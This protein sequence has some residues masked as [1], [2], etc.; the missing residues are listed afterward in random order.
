MHQQDSL[1]Q[2]I[3]AAIKKT[4]NFENFYQRIRPDISPFIA[5]SS[6]LPLKKIDE[7]ERLIRSALYLSCA[8]NSKLKSHLIGS[9]G[10]LDLCNGDG[11]KRERALRTLPGKAPNSFLLALAFRRLNDWVH[12]VRNAACE[13]LL[14]IVESTDPDTVVDVLFITLPYWE[15][16][17]RMGATEKKVIMKIFTM[18]K[19]TNALKRRLIISTSGPVTAIFTQTG[20]TD[21]LDAFLPEIAT[22]SVQPSLRAKA[23]RCQFESKFVWA[24]G[25]KWQWT[26]KIYGKQRLVPALNQRMICTTTPFIDTLKMATLDRSPMVRR[27]AG[28]MLIKE[29]DHVGE[30][31]AFTLANLLASDS[32]QSVAERGKYALAELKKQK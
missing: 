24:E 30:E 20:R 19:V 22:N 1:Q 16:W 28:E 11:H 12:Q 21:A 31:E 5:A 26:D 15:S 8:P 29:L 27:I 14:P 17:G 2:E 4:L 7:W 25:M 10:W 23:F 32:S 9:L 13:T 3:V 6:Q 18:E